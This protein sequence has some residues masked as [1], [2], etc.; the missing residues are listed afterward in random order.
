[1]N[2]DHQPSVPTL[3]ISFNDLAVLRAVILGYLTMIRRTIPHSQERQRQIGL[4]E[5]VYQRLARAPGSV[6]LLRLP[7]TLP[8]IY[9]LNSAMS[10]FAAFVRQRAPP[11]N[12]RD[13]TLQSLEELRRALLWMLVPTGHKDYSGIDNGP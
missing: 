1:M 5:G 2:N 12:E 3:P 9:A 11:S 4:L 10:G 6:S 13:E 8:E 7:L